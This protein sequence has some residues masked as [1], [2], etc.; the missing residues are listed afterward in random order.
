MPS[1]LRR[2]NNRRTS[3]LSIVI[4][5]GLPSP[6]VL[7]YFSITVVIITG[8]STSVITGLST[9]VIITG[10][11]APIIIACLSSLVGIA[12]RLT[13]AITIPRFRVA[14]LLTEF[15][16]PIKSKHHIVISL[17][18]HPDNKHHSVGSWRK[19]R[20]ATVFVM[21]PGSCSC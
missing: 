13:I 2:K 6:A 7:V 3:I 20:S 17:E 12:S 9:P 14:I 19:Q 16:P 5:V 8:L 11:S 15:S 21:P 1:S 10:L 4:V 18:S